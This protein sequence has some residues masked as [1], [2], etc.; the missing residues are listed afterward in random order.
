MYTNKRFVS[1]TDAAASL[2][3][4]YS[5]MRK[6]IRQ[7]KVNIVR[8]GRK[9]LIPEEEVERLIRELAEGRR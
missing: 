2:G 5:M 7:G 9:I 1:L 3:I 8:I 6:L 4:S